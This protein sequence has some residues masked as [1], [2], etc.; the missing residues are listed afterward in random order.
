MTIGI[1][2]ATWA[3]AKASKR[4]DS[5]YDFANWITIATLDTFS[6]ALNPDEVFS[7]EHLM[8]S[9]GVAATVTGGIKMADKVAPGIVSVKDDIARVYD[10]LCKKKTMGTGKTANKIDN[11]ANDI[12]KWI[13]KDGRVITNA[14]GDKIFLSKDGTRKVRF[15]INNPLPHNNPHGHVEQ[16]INGKWMKSGPL[17]P[18]DVPHN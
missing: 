5:V 7:A 9:L 3:G 8:D 2:D 18:T 6:G 4:Y 15:D 12:N 17:Y 10:D 11:L 13:G 16:L 14:S 1:L